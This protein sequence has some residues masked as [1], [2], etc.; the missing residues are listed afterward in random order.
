[1]AVFYN[2]SSLSEDPAGIKVI[3]NPTKTLKAVLF[4]REYL[5]E[6]NRMTEATQAG[7]YI[8]Y[9]TIDKNEQPHIYIGQTGYNIISRLN[10]HNRNKDFW[11]QALVF[12]EKGDF[13]NLNSA[14]AK[15]IE[16]ILIEN[17]VKCGAVVMDNNTG[18]KAPRV[19]K[20]DQLASATWAGEVMT[21]TKILGLAFFVPQVTEE[22][23]ETVTEA[24]DGSTPQG[25][26]ISIPD[27]T[28]TMSRKHLGTKTTYHGTM[29]VKNGNCILKAGS[30]VV[31]VLRK[32]MSKGWEETWRKAVEAGG[33]LPEDVLMDS[34]SGCAAIIT[35]GSCNGWMAWKNADGAYIDVY[36]KT[37]G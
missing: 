17:A 35:G 12:V 14:H 36:R 20:A 33:V 15:I 26:W 32:G 4:P 13:L 19:Q 30:E 18:S 3:E 8:L 11:N 5:P 25:R 34:P 23:T 7:V 10:S 21:I 31:P 22:Q 27:G 16:S 1:M 29:E 9:N 28:Y 6:F 2:I 37:E 24:D